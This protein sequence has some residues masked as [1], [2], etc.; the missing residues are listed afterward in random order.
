MYCIQVSFVT[1]WPTLYGILSPLLVFNMCTIHI[2]ILQLKSD[3]VS[4]L[5][6]MYITVNEFQPLLYRER[7]AVG[8]FYQ[9]KVC[10]PSVPY[11]TLF[12]K[13][14]YAIPTCRI[15]IS[16]RTECNDINKS[17][18][19]S[20]KCIRYIGILSIALRT[21]KNKD[22]KQTKDRQKQIW[23]SKALWNVLTR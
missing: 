19:H 13:L 9:V 21:K 22:K 4:R 14:S 16:R 23:S 10:I 8:T 2:S 11:Y 7:A 1:F 12:M 3:I 18:R 17:I 15:S 6:S 5:N 20:Q